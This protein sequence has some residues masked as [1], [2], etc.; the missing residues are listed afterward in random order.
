MLIN[1]SVTVAY[2]CSSC[3]RFE[4]FDVSCFELVSRKNYFAACQ[5]SN[6]SIQIC[7]EGS[8]AYKVKIDCIGCGNIHTFTLGRKDLLSKDISV[9]ICPLTG[10]QQ[11]FIGDGD[12]VRSKIDSLEKELDE[13]IDRLG[14]DNYFKNTRVMYD[15]LNH[16]HDIAEQGKLVCKCGNK[17]I[18][19]GLLSEKISMR[20]RKCNASADVMAASNEDLRGLLSTRQIV[21]GKSRNHHDCGFKRIFMK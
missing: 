1:T 21:L 20:C 10:I 13:L 9:F 3:G 6:S 7:R 5:C 8:K 19:L 16:I 17:D 11:C 2:M 14:Y 15:S 4:F 12:L 18:E